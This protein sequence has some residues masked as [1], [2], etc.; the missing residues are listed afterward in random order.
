L[1]VTKLSEDG[2]A[3]THGI[4]LG[5]V[6]LKVGGVE[7]TSNIAFSRELSKHDEGTLLSINRD[8]QDL[9]ITMPKGK[10]GLVAEEQDLDIKRR[11]ID[12]EARQLSRSVAVVTMDS[13]DGF[14]TET[15]LGIV[16]SEYAVGM[17]LIKDVLV[18]SRDIFGGRSKVVQDAF[19]E[20]KEVSLTEIRKEAYEL[21]ANAVLGVRFQHS[22]MSG[23]STTMLLMVISGTAAVIRKSDRR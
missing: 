20:A 13:I 16:S 17:N 1:T 22:Q 11:R 21:G 4:L 2:L 10:L 6:V 19:K 18:S 12:F 7:V 14:T 3:Y 8:G 23:A 9:E 15:V 5:D